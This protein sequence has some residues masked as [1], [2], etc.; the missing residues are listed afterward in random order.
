MRK[1]IIYL[2]FGILLFS[3]CKNS[4]TVK[5]ENISKVESVENKTEI[6]YL[7]S[8]ETLI[9]ELGKIWNCQSLSIAK[10]E[11][12]W[13]GK[14]TTSITILVNNTQEKLT[15]EN[16]E[17]YNQ[18]VE[19]IKKNIQNLNDFEKLNIY[20]SFKNAENIQLN[21]KKEFLISELN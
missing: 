19:N 16:S 10:S 8:K 7:K 9:S 13:N 18:S 20:Y 4:P 12:N 14:V 1:E 5:S 2:F 3:N 11:S 17:A 15:K 21:G 6:K